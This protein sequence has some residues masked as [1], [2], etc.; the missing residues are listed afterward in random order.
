MTT[1]SARR[2]R[3]PVRAWFLAGGAIAVVAFLWW[4]GL[5]PC[6]SIVRGDIELLVFFPLSLSTILFAGIGAA[7]LYVDDRNGIGWLLLIIGATFGMALAL[8]LSSDCLASGPA[9]PGGLFLL[10]FS[11]TFGSLTV[12]PIFVFLPMLFPTGR[13]LASNWR[14]IAWI[15]TVALVAAQ[16]ILAFV[17]GEMQYNLSGFTSTAENPFA[18][19]ML[20]QALGPPLMTISWLLTVLLAVFGIVSFGVRFRRSTGDE[21]QQL[22]WFA[23]FMVTIVGGYIVLV[24][25]LAAMLFPALLTTWLYQLILLVVFWG[26][27]AVIGIAVFKYR[28]YDI[29]I[30]INRTLVYGSSTALLAFVY[31]GSV[32]ILQRFFTLMTG[33][34]SDLAIVISTLVIALLFNPLRLG[35]QRWIDRRF[36]RRRY[37]AV[38]T[39]QAFARTTRDEADLERITAAVTATVEETVQPTRVCVWLNGYDE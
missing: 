16:L 9:R 10:W 22:K 34:R 32:I 20:P 6:R 39:L 15:G 36:Y 7:V 37:D 31:L 26:F 29:D 13:F 38:L 33:Q 23:Y 28:L 24:E 14:N 18:I 8:A 21:R 5:G 17:P 30:L 19:S 11:Y 4:L 25:F 27:P 3:L 35:I 2:A 12:L 1:A